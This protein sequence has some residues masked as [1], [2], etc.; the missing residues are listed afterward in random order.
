[1]ATHIYSLAISYNCGGQFCQNVL[2][3][4]FDD[5]GF[6]STAGAA[7]ALITAF[8]TANRTKLKNILPAATTLLSYKARSVS[9]VGGFESF[10]NLPAGQ[11]GARAGTIAAS[12]ICV[13][14]LLVPIGNAKAR[15]RVF[16]PGVT[17]TDVENGEYQTGFLTAWLANKDLFS[18]NLTIVGGGGP[19]ATPCIYHRAPPPKVGYTIQYVTLTSYPTTQRRRQRPT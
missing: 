11:V 7:A 2:H 8:D 3:Y 16:L 6:Q 12:G 18:N 14:V 9:Q 5:S 1:M 4:Q 15:G 13:G 10:F 19:T 17:M